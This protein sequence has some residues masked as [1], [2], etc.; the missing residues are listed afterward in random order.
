MINPKKAVNVKSF[1][2][3]NNT[4]K[5]SRLPR[6]GAFAAV[7][8][9]MAVTVKSES[10]KSTKQAMM[11]EP[12]Q[13][14]GRRDQPERFHSHPHTPNT[15]TPMEASPKVPGNFFVFSVTIIV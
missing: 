3:N 5:S 15:K 1:D 6:K 9:V 13:T 10:N 14:C 4:M 7:P 11:P 12:C 8:P 2:A